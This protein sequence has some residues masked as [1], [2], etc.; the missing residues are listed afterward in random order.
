MKSSL[1]A[2]GFHITAVAAYDRFNTHR[3]CVITCF[4]SDPEETHPYRNHVPSGDGLGDCSK[5][6]CEARPPQP[7]AH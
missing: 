2:Y 1:Q 3:L 7:L 5:A 6:R 4:A